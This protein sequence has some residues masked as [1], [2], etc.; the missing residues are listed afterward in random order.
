MDGIR[1][2]FYTP[3]MAFFSFILKQFEGMGREGLGVEGASGEGRK[4]VWVKRD[5][6][7]RMLE[8]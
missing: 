1:D 2:Y 5:G 4:G 8:V 7:A 6:R 3:R